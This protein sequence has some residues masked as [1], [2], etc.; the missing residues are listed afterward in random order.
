MEL[1]CLQFAIY[2]L[3]FIKKK[4]LQIDPGYLGLENGPLIYTEFNLIF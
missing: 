2:F 1:G 4:L 3:N